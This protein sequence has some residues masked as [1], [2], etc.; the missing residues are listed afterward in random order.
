MKEVKFGRKNEASSYFYASNDVLV[1]RRNQNENS[2]EDSFIGLKQ[3]LCDCTALDCFPDTNVD[4]YKIPLDDIS[5][6]QRLKKLK[7]LPEVRFAGRAFIDALTKKPIVYTENIFIKFID[8]LDKERCLDVLKGLNP[9]TFKPLS[10]ASNAYFLKLEEGSGKKVFDISLEL[11][12]RQD[13]EFCHP[14]IVRSN[15]KRTIHPNQWHLKKTKVTYEI[16]VDASANVEAA[17]LISEGEGIVIAVLDDGFDIDHPELNFENKIIAPVDFGS[18]EINYD[19][20]PKVITDVHGTSVAG[21]ACARGMFGSSGVAPKSKLMPVRINNALGSIREAQAFHWA[22]DH[23]ADV[24]SCSWGPPDGEWSDKKDPSHEDVHPLPAVTRL[25]IEYAIKNGRNG[26]GCAIFFAS[27]NGNE[28]VDNDGYAS[29]EKVIAVGACN[30][31]NR[32]S[33]Y[34]DFGKSLWC[35]FPSNDMSHPDPNFTPPVIPPRTMGI[36]TTDRLG[37]I[38]VNHGR[39][40]YGDIW[41]N[42]TNNFG[43][44]SSAC[45]GVAGVAALMLSVNFDL[46]WKEVREVIAKTCDKI[47]SELDGEGGLYDEKGHSIYYGYGRVNA[48]KAVSLALALKSTPY[49]KIN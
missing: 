40:E 39:I 15:R 21:V 29:Y 8:S 5:F 26:K 31:N 19:P 36:W 23:G 41:G 18:K 3:T 22:A 6:D 11:L 9:A 32:R 45:P 42:Y 1:I 43:G 33:A 20:R 10:F 7:V 38:G 28:S 12:H 37:N 46:T 24:I 25:A 14:E 30:D 35:T 17:H 27:G 49:N 48:E 44:T 47:T 34:S 2:P 4:V 16:E 13:V